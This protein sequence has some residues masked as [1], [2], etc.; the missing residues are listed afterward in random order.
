M[1][2]KDAGFASFPEKTDNDGI[3]RSNFNQIADWIEAN[4]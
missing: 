4:L 2:I 1:S 3:M